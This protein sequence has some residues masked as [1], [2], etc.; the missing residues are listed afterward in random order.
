MRIV[1]TKLGKIELKTTNII[2]I[3]KIVI[4]RVFLEI[5]LYPI[6]KLKIILP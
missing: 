3:Q 5:Y 6:I 4:I 1:I 2:S